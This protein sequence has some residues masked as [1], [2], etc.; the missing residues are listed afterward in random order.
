MLISKEAVV[1][2]NKRNKKRL[3]NLGYK[4]TNFGD[5]VSVKIKDLSN[6]SN[7]IITVKCDYCGDNYTLAYVTYTHRKSKDKDCCGKPQCT[8][9]K[10]KEIIKNKYDVNN[11][12]ELDWV[13]EKIN[14]TN[15]ERY[16]CKNPFGNSKVIEKIKKSNLEK[17]GFEHNSQTE[18][19]KEN[20]SKKMKQF[21][22]EHPEKK[23]IKEKN[24]RWIGDAKYKRDE[25][26]TLEYNEWRK[27]VFNR[28]NYTCKCCGMKRIS[29]DQ[30]SLNAHHIYNFADN[31]NLRT[32]INNGITLCEICHNNF[33]K[34]Y[35]KNNTTANQLKEFISQ[36]R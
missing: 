27:Q 34:K 22:I 30:P 1:N 20:F 4:F 13:N 35:G 12:R 2:W 14:S 33:H 28:D 26:A 16:G 3:E 8:G 18:E 6:G 7:A 21:Y 5:G 25:R 10:A 17:Y 29:A 24:P 32:D 36:F 9:Q 11:I 19:W 31:P 15:L 23:L